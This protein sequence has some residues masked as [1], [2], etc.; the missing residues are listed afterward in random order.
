MKLQGA[1]LH[2]GGTALRAQSIPFLLQLRQR[3]LDV[4]HSAYLFAQCCALLL[5]ADGI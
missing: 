3:V 5:H 2:F 4:H 1:N